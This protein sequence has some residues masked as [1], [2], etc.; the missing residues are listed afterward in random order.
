LNLSCNNLGPDAG[1]HITLVR[2]TDLQHLS[3]MNNG[4]GARTDVSVVCFCSS[5]TK[6][7]SLYTDMS[8]RDFLQHF[9]F[10]HPR[11][12]RIRAESYWNSCV[13]HRHCRVEM[14]DTYYN[15]VMYA[16]DSE[17][18]RTF[19]SSSRTK[20]QY[21][22]PAIKYLGA[23]HPLYS[24]LLLAAAACHSFG[25]RDANARFLQP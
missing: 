20:C 23:F 13:Q 16:L 11:N 4:F 22:S 2:L 17:W 1:A 19:F 6:S 25:P 3:V 8:T 9:A 10:E 21:W 18:S 24:L 7:H 15:A 5:L 12:A 14:T